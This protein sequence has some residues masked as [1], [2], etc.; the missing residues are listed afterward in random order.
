[1]D[2]VNANG[3]DYHSR[4][5]FVKSVIYNMCISANETRIAAPSHL[6]RDLHNQ[7]R[8]KGISPSLSKRASDDGKGTKLTKEI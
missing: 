3:L 2:S 4:L 6:V 8:D 1:M 7:L 5:A